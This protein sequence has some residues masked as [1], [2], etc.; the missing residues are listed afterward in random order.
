MRY[1]LVT[2]APR[3]CTCSLAIPIT[4][5]HSILMRSVSLSAVMLCCR[6]RALPPSN[7]IQ[8]AS[9]NEVEPLGCDSCSQRCLT[10]LCCRFRA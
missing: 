4:V 1:M 8:L 3:T 2:H 6:F 10:M 9:G 5:H 7:W